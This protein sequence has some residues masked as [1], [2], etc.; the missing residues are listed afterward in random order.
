MRDS[1][2]LAIPLDRTYHLMITADAGRFADV[3]NGKKFAIIG[4]RSV[5]SKEDKL[6]GTAYVEAALLHPFAKEKPVRYLY[7][8]DHPVPPGWTGVS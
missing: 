5:P 3:I 2:A 1:L 6:R 8:Q 4:G 7:I